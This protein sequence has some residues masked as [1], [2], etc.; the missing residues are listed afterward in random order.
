MA[1]IEKSVKGKACVTQ[2]ELSYEE[3]HGFPCIVKYPGRRG[4]RYSR[5]KIIEATTDENPD[6][7][8]CLLTDD[9]KMVQVHRSEVFHTD[10]DVKRIPSFVSSNLKT[11]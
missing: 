11:T 3:Q 5:A 2:K 9:F 8:T 6:L 1:R 10:P 7:V 4:G